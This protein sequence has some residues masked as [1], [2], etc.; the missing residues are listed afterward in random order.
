[1]ETRAKVWLVWLP[2]FREYY[3]EQ[4]NSRYL[5]QL[6]FFFFFWSFVF[7]GL[8]P[9]HMEVPRLGVS[10]ELQLPAYARAIATPDLSHVCDLHRSSWQQRILDPL[11][12]TGNRTRNLMVPSQICFCCT[13]MG[14]PVLVLLYTWSQTLPP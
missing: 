12:E 6:L 3:R 14:T 10:P 11:S 7:F 13:T 2:V 8:H 9:W 4:C 1:M 5:V